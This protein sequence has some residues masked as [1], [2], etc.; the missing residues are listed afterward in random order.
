MTTCN[1]Q[2]EMVIR[3]RLSW[4]IIGSL[5]W[6]A[7]LLSWQLTESQKRT[8]AERARA[9]RQHRRA[10]QIVET[11]PAAMILCND[12]GLITVYNPNAVAMFGYTRDEAVGMPVHQL[13][14]ERERPAHRKAFDQVVHQLSM[15][16][17]KW[18]STGRMDGTALTKSGEELPVHLS[19]RGIRYG[20]KLEFVAVIQLR[21]N[22]HSE[23]EPIPPEQPLDSLQDDD[24][25][26]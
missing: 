19:I 6:I 9:D 12:R 3:K 23:V 20:A 4:A 7:I 8:A 16:R 17:D 14:V 25:D 21:A 5:I 1:P 2:R 24:A 18:W 13:V 10:E 11:A 22:M 15:K 26:D